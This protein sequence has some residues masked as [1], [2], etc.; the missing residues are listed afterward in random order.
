MCLYC[1][2]FLPT[3]SQRSSLAMSARTLLSLHLWSHLS[4]HFHEIV[5]FTLSIKL[6]SSQCPWS[7]LL[8]TFH[9]VDFLAMS[10][11]LSSSHFPWSWLPRNVHEAVFLAMSMKLTSLQC[12]WSHLSVYA[13]KVTLLAMSMR[14][15]MHHTQCTI[16][17]AAF[18]QPAVLGCP[19]IHQLLCQAFTHWV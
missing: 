11:K 4:H 7:C 3:P 10:M 9:K 14:G 18:T 19:I 12:P 6:T 1:Y 2:F 5:F 17:N 15:R 13:F 16:H 8:H